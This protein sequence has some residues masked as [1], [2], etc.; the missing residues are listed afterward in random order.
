MDNPWRSTKSDAAE[1]FLAA[2]QPRRQSTVVVR[3]RLPWLDGPPQATQRHIPGEFDSVEDL[4]AGDP[5]ISP[6]LAADE[7]SPSGVP[8]RGYLSVAGGD[9]ALRTVGST[10]SL[11]TRPKSGESW[12]KTLSLNSTPRAG[13]VVPTSKDQ[14]KQ[15]LG[16]V[17]ESAQVAIQPSSEYST[18]S[19]SEVYQRPAMPRKDDGYTYDKL[20]GRR[21]SAHPQNREPFYAANNWLQSQHDL[22]LNEPSPGTAQRASTSLSPKTSA[23]APAQHAPRRRESCRSCDA[24][25]ELRQPPKAKAPPR[26]SIAIPPLLTGAPAPTRGPARRETLFAMPSHLMGSSSS[27][28]APHSP[29]NRISSLPV[30][31]PPLRPAVS[32]PLHGDQ[33]QPQSLNR[34]VTGLENLM[35]EALNVARDAAQNGRNEEV[36]SI[37]NSATLALR[38]ASTINENMDNGQ[39]S[40][41]LRLSSD[42]DSIAPDSD[43][44]SIRSTGH[45]VETAP[46][47][48]TMTPQ[49]SQQPVIKDQ[50]KSGDQVPTSRKASFEHADDRDRTIPSDQR[51]MTSTPPR[52]YQPPS[53]DSIVRDFAYAKQKTAKAVAAR[54]LSRSHGAAEDYYNDAGQS[55]TPQ[56]GVR[57]SLSTPIILNKPLPPLPHKAY[58]TPVNEVVPPDHG[59]RQHLPVR[60]VEQVPTN[61]IPPRVSSEMYETAKLNG[62]PP[63]RRHGRRHHHHHLSNFLESADYREKPSDARAIPNADADLKRG[64]SFIT[65][66]RYDPHLEKRESVSKSSSRYSDPPD[67]IERNISL[68]HP[69]RKHISL[70]E[71]QGFSLGR[72]HRRQP[73][74]RE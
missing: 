46:T 58:T 53:A 44:S 15:A 54:A 74:A 28:S 73:I 20:A 13:V 10:P 38:K 26:H 57:P 43:A 40:R 34:A 55:V 5:V 23:Q 31:P 22:S 2:N 59:R 68:R 29:R 71:G 60:R 6:P 72:Y 67:L 35:G 17:D 51:S 12:F 52:L 66:N 64:D 9:P 11:R 42:S 14:A 27:S 18:T 33:H 39:M 36:A 1:Q 69:R 19:S 25:L 56:P 47:V 37:L 16:I 65:T 50:Y 30:R 45:S 41:P 32:A 24:N 4:N 3:K 49:P 8:Q 70:R 7:K 62:S 48:F 63:R 21:A 61:T